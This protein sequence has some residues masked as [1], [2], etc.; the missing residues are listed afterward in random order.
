MLKILKSKLVDLEN[1]VN[2]KLTVFEI[3]FS[4]N[5]QRNQ[6]KIYWSNLSTKKLS[7]HTY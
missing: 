7:L 1:M 3:I 5:F 2:L 6:Y 4:E